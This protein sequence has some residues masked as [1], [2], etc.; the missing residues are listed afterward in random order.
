MQLFG[1]LFFLSSSF[2]FSFSYV[3]GEMCCVDRESNPLTVR[4]LFITILTIK[5]AGLELNKIEK[6]T[7]LIILLLFYFYSLF[8]T[9]KNKD[10][11][12]TPLFIM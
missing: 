7:S 6:N 12:V 8:L 9:K 3:E 5:P 4:N 11:K 2:R 10:V 1:D